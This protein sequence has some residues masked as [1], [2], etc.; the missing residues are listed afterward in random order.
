[1]SDDNEFEKKKLEYSAAQEMLRH[2]DSLSWQIGSILIAA[3]FLL[4][5]LVLRKESVALIQDKGLYSFAIVVGLPLFSLFVLL[6]WLLW[7]LRCRHLY[8]LRSETL[9]RLEIELG[10]Y[11]HL[12]AVE[13]HSKVQDSACCT[14]RLE[15]AKRNAGYT[16]NRFHPLVK[17]KL[18]PISG[19]ATVHIFVWGIPALQLLLFLVIKF[20]P[21]L[22]A[23]A[24]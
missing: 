1:M 15:T 24:S 5:G 20:S 23:A 7:Y 12:L 11:H 16:E 17:V 22:N 2:Y 18:S 14:A 3:V 19:F 8:N 21:A 13:G 10:F 4:T 6:C 9:H